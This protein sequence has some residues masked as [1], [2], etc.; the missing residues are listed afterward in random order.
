MFERRWPRNTEISRFICFQVEM[1]TLC[2]CASLHKNQN[3]ERHFRESNDFFLCAA[4]L[5]RGKKPFR[6]TYNGVMGC[7]KPSLTCPSRQRI[8]P[9]WDIVLSETNR[10]CHQVQL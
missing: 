8:L 6:A 1:K 9:R 2:A 10:Q 5:G 4:G 7:W 3:Q